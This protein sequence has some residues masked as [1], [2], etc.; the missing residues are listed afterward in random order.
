MTNHDS[1]LGMGQRL[2]NSSS[3][4]HGQM[5]F[6]TKIVLIYRHL[7]GE[8]QDKTPASILFPA[9]SIKTVTRTASV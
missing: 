3:Q 9:H 5:M 4:H 7:L 1:K 2:D 8:D 6:A